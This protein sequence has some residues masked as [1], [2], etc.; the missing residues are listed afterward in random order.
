M[1]RAATAL[2]IFGSSFGLALAQSMSPAVGVTQQQLSAIQA[3]IPMPA[4]SVPLQPTGTGVVGSQATYLPGDSAQ[5]LKV[6]RTTVT[7]N[8][9]G[10]WSVTWGNS[11]VS[12]SPVIIPEVVDNSATFYACKVQTRTASA[13]SGLCQTI[14][15]SGIIALLSLALALPP[16]AAPAGMSVMVVGAEPTQ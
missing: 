9:S 16:A 6:Q 8:S 11:F 2:V 7:T 15:S 4:A 14:G 5:A 13:A 10:I 1:K 12:S 3:L